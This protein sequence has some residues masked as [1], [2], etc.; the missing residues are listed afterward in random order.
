MICGEN[1]QTLKEL[2]NRPIE[3]I[4]L[5]EIQK[6]LE[7][8]SNIIR[9]INT[10]SSIRKGPKGDYLFFKTPR[11]KKPKFY[12]I[13]SFKTELSEDYKICDIDILKSWLSDKYDI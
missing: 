10:D 1:K 7:K 3:N 9:V 6:Y 11:M 5:E 2:G 4:K 13:K 8:E 12:D